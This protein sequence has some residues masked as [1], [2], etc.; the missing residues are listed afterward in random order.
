MPRVE[1]SLPAS[2]AYLSLVR[3]HVGTVASRMDMSIDDVQDLQI[4]TEEL[5][6]SLLRPW[7]REDGQLRID[8]ESSDDVVEIRCQLIDPL[9]ASG[10]PPLAGSQGLPRELSRHILDSLTDEHGE[11]AGDGLR[12]VWL[13]KRTSRA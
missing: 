7:G 3:I 10:D 12:D 9:L 13:R 4:A 6:L 11:S 1:L 8:I 2:S 5:C